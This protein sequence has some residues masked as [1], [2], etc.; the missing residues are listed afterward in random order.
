MSQGRNPVAKMRVTAGIVIA[1][2]EAKLSDVEI[3][4]QNVS[5]G[6]EHLDVFAYM[7]KKPKKP[8]NIAVATIQHV[9]DRYVHPMLIAAFVEA[10]VWYIHVV[11]KKECVCVHI[12]LMGHRV[13]SKD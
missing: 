5:W 3:V 11:H 10:L 4:F 7:T 9:V 1:T 6:V 13:R 8:E 12:V 2:W